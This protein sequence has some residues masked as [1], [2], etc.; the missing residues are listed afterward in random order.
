MERKQSDMSVNEI[1]SFWQM[2]ESLPEGEA[3]D[4]YLNSI[5]TMLFRIFL[6]FQLMKYV[7]KILT[8][9]YIWIY[10]AFKITTCHCYGC[11]CSGSN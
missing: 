5:Q 4:A 8:P 6:N 7:R 2:I 1:T 10:Y 9:I 11:P 3:L